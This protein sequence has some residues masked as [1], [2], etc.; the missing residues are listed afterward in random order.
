MQ[1][2]FVKLRRGET[3]QLPPPIENMEPSGRHR[4]V[5]RATGAGMSLVGD[6]AEVRH[7][8]E[9]HPAGDPGG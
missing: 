9:S 6:K 2:A 3:G 4:A 1:Q 8:L 5:W 7:G